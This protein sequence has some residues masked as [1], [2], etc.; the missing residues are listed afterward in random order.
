MKKILT[1]LTLLGTLGAMAQE[2]TATSYVE[3][4]VAGS[5]MGVSM[6]F[7]FP[8][9]ITVGGFHQEASRL[10]DTKENRSVWNYERAFS[11]AYLVCPVKDYEKVGLDVNVRMG[12][13]NGQNFLITP[14]V[15]GSYQP[16]KLIN[17]GVGVGV[18]SFRPTYQAGISLRLQS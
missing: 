11:G 16:F 8:Y 3:R 18:R 14:S 5:K 2:L 12:V 9:G 6:G 15:W 10:L 4:T 17:V 7:T 1:I 13:S